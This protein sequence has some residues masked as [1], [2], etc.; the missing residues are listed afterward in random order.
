MSIDLIVKNHLCTGCGVCVSEDQTH[1]AKMIWNN[2]GFLVPLLG[3]SS[4][5]DKM[6]KVCPFAIQQKDEDELGELFLKQPETQYH[7]KIGYYYG[8]Y[9]GYSKQFRETS[10]S[11]GIATYV[12]NALL[13]RKIVDY[14]FIVKEVDG[15]YAY[16]FFSNVEEITQISKTRYTPV[17]LEKLFQEL[18]KVDG[19]VAVSG[20]ACFVKAIRLKQMYD[21]VLK[22]KIAFI[23]GIICGGLKSKY[24]TD[25]L[26]QEAGCK[27]EYN[28]AQY[29][30]K[31][32]ES[33]AMDYKFSCIEKSDKKIHMVDMQSLGDMWGTGLFKSNAC[34]FC[35]DVLTEL[36][37]ISLGDAW[38]DPYDKNGLGNSIII[39]RTKIAEN[40]IKNGLNKNLLALDVM[41]TE[42]IILSQNGSFNHRHKG[43]AF[44]VMKVNK[45]GKLTPRKRNKHMVNQ[46]ILFNFVQNS[47]LKTRQKSLDY[48]LE[49][50]NHLKFKIKMKPYLE[51][52]KFF[53]LWNH[54][55]MKLK[56]IL[57]SKK[58]A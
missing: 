27:N 21:P 45:E 35:D 51:N 42:K 22:E 13:E 7:D 28:Y 58:D 48:W 53:T 8:L 54:R 19:K 29:R 36:A 3:K 40:L 18:S 57:L 33:Y 9:A 56:K 46:N 14:L 34:D 30:V 6:V 4:T 52:L 20:V 5:Q 10:S 15:Q 24:Y 38:I 16:Q 31:N 17:T 12:F 41:N 49:T 23:V 44:R 37:D 25:Y 39:T 26:A 2:E 1:Q 32:K 47:R 11:G 50:R 55:L 43:L